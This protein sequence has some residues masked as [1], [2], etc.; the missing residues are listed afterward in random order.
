VNPPDRRGL[1]EKVND[2]GAE[3]NRLFPKPFSAVR[4]RT[5]LQ[6]GYTR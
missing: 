5:M 6:N 2:L 4:K 1:A 3:G